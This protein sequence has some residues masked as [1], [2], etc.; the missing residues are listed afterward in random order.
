MADTKIIVLH[1]KPHMDDVVGAWLLCRYGDF[2][3]C[4]FQFISV[5]KPV[6][7]PDADHSRVYVG[8]GLSRYDEHTGKMGQTAATLV[9]ND[10]KKSLVVT[11]VRYKALERLVDWT[12]KED[13]GLLK[14]SQWHDFSVSAI[15]SGASTLF[16]EVT[17]E[18]YIQATFFILDS[19]VAYYE[20]E[21]LLEIDWHARVEF[22]SSWGKGIAL[23]TKAKG[24]DG[25]AYQKGFILTV[26]INPMD[27]SCSIKAAAES[28]ID[29]TTVFNRLKDQYS[30]R[31]WFLHHSKKMI[32]TGGIGQL[33]NGFSLKDI[34][35][36]MM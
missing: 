24:L 14:S 35:S 6:L 12:K 21:A 34:I 10:I 23:L 16:N 32:I 17:N 9:W 20:N 13:L 29:L 2:A 33:N 1:L 11:T 7:N 26:S 4:Q 28:D 8:V 5:K 15:F 18:Q 3:G 25:F 31:D 30:N 27:N 22:S 36:L 19:L